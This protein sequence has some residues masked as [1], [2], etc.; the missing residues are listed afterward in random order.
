MHPVNLRRPDSIAEGWIPCYHASTIAKC[1][2]DSPMGGC[3]FVDETVRTKWRTH[4]LRGVSGFAPPIKKRKKTAAKKNVETRNRTPISHNDGYEWKAHGRKVIGT[5][6]HLVKRRYFRCASAG[7][8]V[9]KV[10][11]SKATWSRDDLVISYFGSHNHK[12]L[13]PKSPK[14]ETQ[15]ERYNESSSES[16]SMEKPPILNPATNFALGNSNSSPRQDDTC[17]VSSKENHT[18]LVI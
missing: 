2:T 10:M 11:D 3:L 9:R 13:E 7:C 14:L 1:T 8:Q 16:H 18:I 5:T 15:V 4:T 12:P 17:G 6:E